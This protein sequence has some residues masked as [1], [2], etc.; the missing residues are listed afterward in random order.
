MNLKCSVVALRM[1]FLGSVLTNFT[2]AGLATWG[3]VPWFCLCLQKTFLENLM[4]LLFSFSLC[5]CRYNAAQMSTSP[6]RQLTSSAAS[7]TL[8]VSDTPSTT[9]SL[10]RY[11]PSTGTVSSTYTPSSSYAPGSLS[12]YSGG[13]SYPVS[14]PM[15]TYYTPSSVGAGSTS[16]SSGESILPLIGRG[17]TTWMLTCNIIRHVNE[18]PT[19]HHFHC[20]PFPFNSQTH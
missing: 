6:T 2:F 7:S 3:L 8:S 1:R 16:S 11:N 15:S 9:L 4:V 14:S 20:V 19:M 10:P 17:N 12:A 5:T 18:Y 13:S